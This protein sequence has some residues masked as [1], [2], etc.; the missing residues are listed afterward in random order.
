M[1]IHIACVY[2]T[3]VFSSLCVCVDRVCVHRV[4]CVCLQSVLRS[5]LGLQCFHVGNVMCVLLAENLHLEGVVLPNGKE[6]VNSDHSPIPL[7]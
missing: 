3:S 2:C 5:S 7:L 1:F 6:G 4:Q